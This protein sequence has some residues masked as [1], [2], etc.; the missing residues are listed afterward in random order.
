[1]ECV[2]DGEKDGSDGGRENRIREEEG[3]YRKGVTLGMN[4]GAGKWIEEGREGGMTED[5]RE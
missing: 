1:M 3:V 4:E 2:E 5:E